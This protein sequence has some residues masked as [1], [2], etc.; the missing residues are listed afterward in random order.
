MEKEV[1]TKRKE[2]LGKKKLGSQT[3][4]HKRKQRINEQKVIG[5]TE[6]NPKV[7]F[8]HANKAKNKKS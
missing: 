8:S 6:R 5:I 2:E 3:E 4:S 7:S 1:S